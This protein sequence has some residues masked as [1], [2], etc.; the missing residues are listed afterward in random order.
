MNS[1]VLEMVCTDAWYL[2]KFGR[3]R[4]PM[5]SPHSLWFQLATDLI[6]NSWDETGVRR[7]A[8]IFSSGSGSPDAGVVLGQPRSG[9]D[10]HLTP[11]KRLR[12]TRT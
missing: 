9:T 10:V 12:P 4:R 11:T 7:R 5:M 8:S 3:R 6:N 2:Y 1:T